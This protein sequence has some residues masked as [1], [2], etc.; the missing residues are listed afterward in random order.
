MQ[1]AYL[2]TAYLFARRDLE[3]AKGTEDEPLARAIL[4]RAIDRLS[5]FSR[6]HLN[7]R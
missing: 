2:Y 4:Q 3:R 7:K 5:D 1:Y 6:K